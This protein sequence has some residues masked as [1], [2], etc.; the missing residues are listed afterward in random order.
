MS[1][2]NVKETVKKRYGALAAMNTESCC[3]PPAASSCCGPA[4]EE[5]RSKDI[6]YSDEEI[7]SLPEGANLGLGCGNPLALAELKIGDTVVDLG[8]GGGIDCFLAS[9]RVGLEGQVIGV[10]MTPEMLERARANAHKGGYTNVE[11]RQGEIEALPIDDDTVDVVISNCVINLSPDKPQVFKEMFRVLKPGGSFFVSDLVL[12]KPL[13]ESIRESAAAYVACVGGATLKAEYLG[14][15]SDAGFGSVEVTSEVHFPI[16]SFF[17]DP[18]VA[19]F[20]QDIEKVPAD[21]VKD[22]I[23]SLKSIKVR[24]SKPQ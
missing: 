22:A 9:K 8:S 23:D 19:E 10:D 15:M 2:I 12:T 4:A 24:G 6:G 14:A 17:S 7:G 20:V 18:K 11:F 21:D 3:A 5:V 16:E 1:G 13:P